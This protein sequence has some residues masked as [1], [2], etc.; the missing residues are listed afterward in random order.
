MMQALNHG[1]QDLKVERARK[2]TKAY[3]II[4]SSNRRT[5]G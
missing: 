3:T 4:R 1:K 5:E 2:R